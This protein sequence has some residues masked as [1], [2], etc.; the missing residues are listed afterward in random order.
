MAV[1]NGERVLCQA[2]DSIVGQTYR[3][4]E[5]IISDNASTDMT[6]EICLEYAAGDPRIR[7]HRN[8]VNVGVTQ[9]YR[10]VFEL[11]LGEYFMWAAVDDIKPPDAVEN[12]LDALLRNE[13]AVMAHGPI[14]MKVEGRDDLLEV[15]NDI[16]M[17]NLKAGERVR[18]FTTGLKTQG[19]LYGLYRRSALARA[20][21][22][23]CYGQEY[24]LC[25]QMCLLGPLE[26]VRTPMIVYRQRKPILNDNPMYMEVPITFM[27]LLTVSGHIRRKCWAVLLAGCY[28]LMKVRGVRYTHR[29]TA[30][31]AHMSALP[32]LYR[33]RFAKEII[34]Q[35]FEPAAWLSSLLWQVARQWSFSWRV[36]RRLKAILS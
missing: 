21:F 6:R 20:T 24:L 16:E 10:R 22:S 14:L 32:I 36:A 28:Y 27:N 2:L 35:L 9:N 3:N 29:V 12:C 4:L 26:C 11:S 31:A 33:R 25:L 1:Y 30:I 7:Y 34:F 5:V 13:R 19:I 8:A 15:H 23:N 18:V 17:C